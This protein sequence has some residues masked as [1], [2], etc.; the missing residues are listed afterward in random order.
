M[1]VFTCFVF[2]V[3]MMCI[4]ITNTCVLQYRDHDDM[5]STRKNNFDALFVFCASYGKSIH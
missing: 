4:S 5:V 3:N 1:I 2:C